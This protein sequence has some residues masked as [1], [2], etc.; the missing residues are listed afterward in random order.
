MHMTVN[1]YPMRCGAASVRLPPGQNVVGRAVSR[2][3]MNTE[4]CL[5][6]PRLPAF[7][8]SRPIHAKMDTAKLTLRGEP[9]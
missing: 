8:M 6:N 7:V 2:Q 5:T 3:A 4:P 9:I 1:G